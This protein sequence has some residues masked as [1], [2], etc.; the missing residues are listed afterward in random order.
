MI[1][2]VHARRADLLLAGSK[3]F[4]GDHLAKIAWKCFLSWFPLLQGFCIP[5]WHLHEENGLKLACKLHSCFSRLC[6]AR[7]SCLVW[8][9]DDSATYHRPALQLSPSCYQDISHIEL[10]PGPLNRDVCKFSCCPSLLHC[11]L[12]FLIFLPV[13]QQRE[14]KN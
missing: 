10:C 14:V 9:K 6:I 2:L 8:A 11:V 7:A 5:A 4:T 13:E 3:G 12:C 1:L